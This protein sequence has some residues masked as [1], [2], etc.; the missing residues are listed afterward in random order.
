MKDSTW[1]AVYTRPG[2]FL[3]ETLGRDRSQNNMNFKI[4]PSR[5]NIIL[6]LQKKTEVKQF[7]QGTTWSG[8]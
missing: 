1:P 2:I 8:W 4:F 6:T 5:N 7:V 3:R